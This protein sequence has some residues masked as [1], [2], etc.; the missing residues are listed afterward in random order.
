MIGV[1]EFGWRD[2]KGKLDR[3]KGAESFELE[4]KEFS[5]NIWSKNF[6]FE[7]NG[8]F[9]RI[10]GVFE[11]E[12]RDSKGKFDKLKGA[13][14]FKLEFREFFDSIWLKKFCFE[15]NGAFKRI[16]EVFELEWRGLK[17]ELDICE[18]AKGCDNLV[19]CGSLI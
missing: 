4:F 10:V 3:L 8:A 15:D 6:W 7:D 19:K 1:F 17:G 11:L 13:K 16:I 5:V 2:L 14:S 18:G 12:W 9:K